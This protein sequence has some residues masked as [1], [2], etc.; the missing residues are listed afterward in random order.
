M[1]WCIYL[2]NNFSLYHEI[3]IF[4]FLPQDVGFYQQ[5]KYVKEMSELLTPVMLDD[6]VQ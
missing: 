4:F 2:K 1:S 5:L 3:N 6:V